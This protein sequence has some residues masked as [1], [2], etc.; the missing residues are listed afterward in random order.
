M[1]VVLPKAKEWTAYE[2]IGQ[3][4]DELHFPVFARKGNLPRQLLIG[5]LD[6]VERRESARLAALMREMPRGRADLFN[7]ALG[8][9][10]KSY[11]IWTYMGL[12]IPITNTILSSTTSSSVPLVQLLTSASIDSWDEVDDDSLAAVATAVANTCRRRRQQQQ[13]HEDDSSSS[14]SVID[15]TMSPMALALQQLSLAASSLK[16]PEATSSR[17]PARLGSSPT[18]FNN[19][20]DNSSFSSS[21]VENRDPGS[22]FEAPTPQV[23]NKTSRRLSFLT[24]ASSR[25]SLSP[26]NDSSTNVANF[27]VNNDNEYD[28]ND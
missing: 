18:I 13:Q 17:L 10:S 22:D 15:L 9:V 3:L 21:D 5:V 23:I 20:N 1:A 25:L 12:T 28:D 2:Q 6:D 27:N 26:L 16:I 19:N 24:K 11:L 4:F 8:H 14:S 7:L